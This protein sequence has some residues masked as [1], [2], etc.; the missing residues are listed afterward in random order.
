MVLVKNVKPIKT[1]VEEE[2]Q[3]ILKELVK[4]NHKYV[5]HQENVNYLHVNITQITDITF[6]L[7]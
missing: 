7:I 5:V 3:D 4:T 2:E 6:I 1:E